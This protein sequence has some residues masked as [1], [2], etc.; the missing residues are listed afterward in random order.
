MLSEA[1]LNRLTLCS[2]LVCAVLLVGIAQLLLAKH[3]TTIELTA[4]KQDMLMMSAQSQA[5]AQ[6]LTQTTLERAK[7]AAQNFSFFN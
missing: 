3:R 7:D 1:T 2:L 6:R 4:L 5:L